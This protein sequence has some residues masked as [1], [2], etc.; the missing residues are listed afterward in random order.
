MKSAHHFFNNPAHGMTHT[1][2]D[3]KN[4]HTI[5]AFLLEVTNS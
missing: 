2:T 1:Q 4:D 3:R 5:S